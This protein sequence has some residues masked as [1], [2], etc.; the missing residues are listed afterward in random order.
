M[1]FNHISKKLTEGQVTALRILYH[2]Y[3]K[4]FWCY[5]KMFKKYRNLDLALKLSSV[6]L[7]TT[8]AVIG[9]VTS[10]PILLGVVSSSGVLLQTITTQKNFSKKTEACR[11]AYQSYKKILNKIKLFLRS[12][13]LDEFFERELALV[14]DHV[15]DICPPISESYVK[16]HA[17]RFTSTC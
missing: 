8:G 11:Y 17:K 4:Q 12:G 2:T 10:N 7:T 16:L 1:D 9:S 13:D 6:I 3:H 15:V 5:K 14:D